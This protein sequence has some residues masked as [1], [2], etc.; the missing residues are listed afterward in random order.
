[1]VVLGMLVILGKQNP[2]ENSEVIWTCV[3]GI[4]AKWRQL[5]QE[6]LKPEANSFHK[7]HQHTHLYIKE[8]KE[9]VSSVD[10]TDC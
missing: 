9:R 7:P 3:V 4:R 10:S 8:T 5:T 6:M 2:A 1:M